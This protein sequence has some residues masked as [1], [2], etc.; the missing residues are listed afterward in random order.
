M[1]VARNNALRETATVDMGFVRFMRNECT[2]DAGKFGPRVSTG[3]SA[4]SGTTVPPWRQPVVLP[5]HLAPEVHQLHL[6]WGCVN[7]RG[8]CATARGDRQSHVGIR[9][10]RNSPQYSQGWHGDCN[11]EGAGRS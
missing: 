6:L 1:P 10:G 11:G 8:P 9:L 3:P 5:A 7:P 4:P 2:A